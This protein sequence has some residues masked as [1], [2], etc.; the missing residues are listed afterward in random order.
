[1]M[2]KK[3]RDVENDLKELTS[4]E[5]A[6]ILTNKLLKGKGTISKN[7]TQRTMGPTQLKWI[8]NPEEA[9]QIQISISTSHQR[10]VVGK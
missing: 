3:T 10:N 9:S 7:M 1:M 6:M 5:R 4:S 8:D 2:K